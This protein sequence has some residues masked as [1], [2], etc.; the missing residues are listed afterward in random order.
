MAAVMQKI[1]V[2]L[3]DDQK[4]ALKSIAARTGQKQSDLV[5]K[6]VDL[7][8]DKARRDEADWRAATRS[9]A[10]MWRDRT[11]L[12]PISEA[13]RAAVKRRFSSVHKRG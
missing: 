5:R 8:I 7:L 10:G 11:D 3:R 13:F 12:E 1:Q 4:A 2:F 6:S 9:V